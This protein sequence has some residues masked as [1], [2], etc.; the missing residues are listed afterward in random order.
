MQEPCPG[1]GG[2]VGLAGSEQPVLR[3]QPSLTPPIQEPCGGS[4]CASSAASRVPLCFC[5][6][7]S[8]P[9]VL[10]KPRG[11][12]RRP[13]KEGRPGEKEVVHWSS[14]TVG[15]TLAMTPLK[16]LSAHPCQHTCVQPEACAPPACLIRSLH[17]SRVQMMPVGAKM[18][19]S[20]STQ[21]G[22]GE[23]SPLSSHTPVCMFMNAPTGHWSIYPRQYCPSKDYPS[24]FDLGL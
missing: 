19:L 15:E 17:L 24:I 14:Q 21:G 2:P 11:I 10:R 3:V 22:G 5:G 16:L 12:M 13:R 7:S 18:H 8:F 4:A 9:G 6:F 20:V 1:P 23:G